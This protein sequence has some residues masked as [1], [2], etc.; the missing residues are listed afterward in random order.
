MP[1]PTKLRD[2]I[3]GALADSGDPEDEAL[4]IE[5]LMRRLGQAMLIE[6][7]DGTVFVRRPALRPVK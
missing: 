1:E 4:V 3:A 7:D 6:L 2:V 5:I